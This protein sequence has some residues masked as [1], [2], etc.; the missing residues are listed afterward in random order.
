MKKI[1]GLLFL[2]LIGVAEAQIDSAH[3]VGRVDLACQHI[4]ERGVM[5]DEIGLHV[6]ARSGN[7][8]SQAHDRCS[9]RAERGLAIDSRMSVACLP[10]VRT[11][12]DVMGLPR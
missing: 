9:F 2:G 4:D 6:A 12:R 3:D 10:S 11:D 1:I 7:P 8:V 5:E